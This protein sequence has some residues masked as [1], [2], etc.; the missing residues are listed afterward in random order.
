MERLIRLSQYMYL[1]H[2]NHFFVISIDSPISTEVHINILLRESVITYH[3]RGGL[4]SFVYATHF[5]VVCS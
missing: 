5:M 2:D 4:I 3:T 1:Q